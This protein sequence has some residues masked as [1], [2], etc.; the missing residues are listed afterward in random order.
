M[1]DQ[2]IYSKPGNRLH[3][4]AKLRNEMPA[5]QKYLALGKAKR[6][7]PTSE[8]YKL[9][10]AAAQIQ[11]GIQKKTGYPLKLRNDSMNELLACLGLWMIDNGVGDAQE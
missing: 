9:D 6:A 3:E 7:M 10:G 2:H 11:N 4:F 5:E 8:R 1:R